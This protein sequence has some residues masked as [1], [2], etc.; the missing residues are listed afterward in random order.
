LLP[1]SLGHPNGNPY[2]G[3]LAFLILPAVFLGGLLLIP[4]GIAIKRRRGPPESRDKIGPLVLTSANPEWM[5]LVRFLAVT[6]VMNIAIAGYAAFGAVSYMDSNSFCGRACHF[7]MAPE[8]TAL[9]AGS[10]A[11]VECVACHIGP[12]A[13]GFIKA[14]M[15]G[16]RQLAMLATN[17]Y[18][19]P[20]PGAADSMMPA[21]VRC[22][23]CHS[24]I[25][26]TG[27]KLVI[28]SRFNDDEQ[29]TPA[30]T[31]LA[32][33]VGKIHSTHVDNLDCLECHNRPAHRFES[34]EAGVDA[35]LARAAISR[36]LPFARKQGVAILQKPYASREVAAAQ[37]PA[38]FADYYRQTY[39][40]VSSKNSAEIA[41]A[42]TELAAIYAR[43]VY[44]DLKLGWNAHPSNLGHTE[45]PGCFRCHDGGAITQ[46]CGTCHN[47][48]AVG[49]ADPQIL[50]DL[51]MAGTP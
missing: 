1:A 26:Q 8:Y 45:A 38:A 5:K 18:S 23:R 47:L 36:A 33:H 44:P 17:T 32:V 15:G 4:I 19:R 14:K 9:A 7:V 22:E 16:I 51:G 24:L 40:D 41:G 6:T 10:H 50:K 13:A 35:A 2:F 3:I 30:T 31:V 49:E 12:G 34:P 28:F 39:P 20:I 42:G 21:K 48:L 43:N 27:D 37:I 25:R 11:Q 46:D 29:N